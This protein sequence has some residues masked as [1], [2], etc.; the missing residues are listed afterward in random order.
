MKKQLFISLIPDEPE[1]VEYR[2][3]IEELSQDLPIEHYKTFCGRLRSKKSNEFQS[4]LFEMQL[5]RMLKRLDLD[6]EIEGEFLG[7]KK[8]IDFHVQNDCQSCFIE[9]TVWLRTR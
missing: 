9:A 1:F 5:Y 4:T 2:Q 3:W 7:T 6:V 8:K